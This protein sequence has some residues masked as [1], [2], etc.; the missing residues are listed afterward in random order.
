MKDHILCREDFMDFPIGEFPYDPDHT[1]MGEYQYVT[2]KGYRGRWLDQV[3]NYTWNGTGPTWLI[4]GQDGRH[5]MECMRV[6]KNN[7]HRI[8]PT[9]ETGTPFWKNYTVSV[10]LRRLSLG[11]MAG[12]VFCLNHSIDT[13][14]FALEDR[15][16]AALR[17]RHK[18]DILLLGQAA[19]PQDPDDTY[20]LSVD[21]QDD[22][23]RCYVNGVLL[24]EA[25]TP[26]AAR[27]GKVGITADCP[28]RF[29]DF[30]ARTTAE[31]ARAI[32]ARAAAHK[33]REA[34][35]QAKHP[36]MKLWKK[37][38]LGNFG[39]SRQAR[40]G[41]LL[42]DG[43]WQ[44]VLAQMQ[45][46]VSRDAYGFISCLT[47]VDL[48][49]KVLWQLGEP[50]DQA[51]RLGRVSADMAL[52]VY[53]IDG[54]G[55]DEVICGWD[56]EIRI[57]DGRTGRVKRAAKTPVADQED[58]GLIGAPY[59]VYAFA[60][61]NPD[62]IRICNLRGLPQ[63]RDILIKDR[64]CRLWA[65]DDELNTL[66]H[67][68][69]PTNTGHCPLPVD[70]DGDGKDELLAGYRLLDSDGTELWH[71]PIEKDH[72]DEIVAGRWKPDD[73]A[74]YFACVSG[75]QGFF[76]GDFYGNILKRDGI[77]HAQRVSVANYCPDRKGLEIAVTNFWGHQGGIFLY[78]CDGEPIWEMQNEMN[79]NIIAP[80][81][82]DG[83]GAEL[84]LT[85]AD[86]DGGG[87]LNGAG[88]RAVSFPDDGHPVLCCE[89]LDLC[90]DERDELIVWDY[91]SMYIYTQADNPKPQTYHPCKFPAYNASNYRGEY[92]F[93]DRGFL[94]FRA[95][96]SLLRPR[97]RAGRAKGQNND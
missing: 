12:L 38:D 52:Q 35:E 84:I 39:T 11:G 50:S 57:L 74:G 94:A 15:E 64:Y 91:H 18:E 33:A 6:E 41:H 85:N 2:E 16:T 78:D 5:A 21:C 62:G 68:K 58:E 3:C 93:P 90:G 81:N 1:A 80:V 27:G 29:S 37:I 26:L 82:W 34:A 67:D 55:F 66:W 51:E 73:P 54:D 86:P 92:A 9:L 61:L 36:A 69:S 28:A 14:V 59:G 44:V 42:G 43:N 75:T 71:Y 25:R 20:R 8:F 95:D 31:E 30:E 24:I 56:F 19:F 87:L 60:R 22:L 77:G 10:S 48:D 47:A 76:I 46:R 23:A 49:G 13:L 40:F 72:T 83:D 4:T 65:L 17:Y 88:L 79:G 70:V 53:D 96:R 97:D 7:P 63:P 89:C 32:A 45:R